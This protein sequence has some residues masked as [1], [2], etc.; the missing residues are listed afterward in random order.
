M[1]EELGL[2][3]V[4]EPDTT[5]LDE[6]L[7]GIK[8]GTPIKMPVTV[9]TSGISSKNIE[10]KLGKV[11]VEVDIDDS[12]INAYKSRLKGLGFGD[13]AVKDAVKALNSMGIQVKKVRSNID[14]V[15]AAG[16]KLKSVIFDGVNAEGDAVRVTQQYNL[17]KKKQLET[18]IS[19]T[20]EYEKQVKA[21]KNVAEETAKWKTTQENA[22]KDLVSKAKNQTKPLEQACSG[23]FDGIVSNIRNA[24]NQVGDS[25]TAETKNSVS[26]MMADAARALKEA[27]N[28]QYVATSLRTKDIETVKTIQGNTLSAFE[29]KIKGAGMS[30]EMSTTV[31][32]L[33]ENLAK[34]FDANSLT[35]W[36]NQLD[37]ARSKLDALTAEVKAQAAVEKAAAKAQTD[38]EKATKKAQKEQSQ[39]NIFNS[40]K[41]TA[42]TKLDSRIQELERA[43]QYAGKIKDD[44]D[45]LKLSLE[46]VTNA[47][48]L[49]A[50][51]AELEIA[52]AKVKQFQDS[53]SALANQQADDIGSNQL[54]QIEEFQQRL[55][56]FG[57][58]E[59]FNNLR[60][61]LENLKSQ[62]QDVVNLLNNPDLSEAEYSALTKRIKELDQQ[63]KKTAS[64]M[65]KFG[66]DDKSQQYIA[67]MESNIAKLKENFAA[68]KENWSA[69]MDVPE[70]KTQIDAFEQRLQGVDASNVGEVQAAFQRL[71]SAIKSAG[72]DC[73]SFSS[74]LSEIKQYATQLFSWQQIAQ[75]AKKFFTEVVKNVKSLDSA[76][77]ELKKVTDLTSAGYDKFLSNAGSRAK[78]I[79]TSMSSYIEGVGDFAKLGYSVEDATA[80]SEAANIL[81]KVGD[82]FNSIEDSSDTIIASMKAYGIAASDVTSVIDKLNEVSNKTSITTSGLSEAIT[83]SASALSA[84]GLSFDKSLALIVAGNESTRDPSMVGN[85]LKTLSLRIRGAETELEALGEETDEYVKSTSK[86]REEVKALTG[87]DIMIDDSQFKDLYD[88]MDE[89]EEKFLALSDIDRANLMDILFG[90]QRA[91]VG[92][93]ILQNFDQ[94]E[95]ALETA[96]NA[97]GSAMTEHSRWMESI[98]ASE[99]KATAAFEELSSKIMSSDI[100]KFFYDAKTGISEF[101][102]S[103]IDSTGSAIPLVASLGATLASLKSNLGISIVNMPCFAGYGVAA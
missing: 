51:T 35:A 58:T 36:L 56:N 20:H 91:N 54:K 40:K 67:R 28:K 41:E 102:S 61:Q 33:K 27:Q 55:N 88:I 21:Q 83:R 23:T 9:D 43:G 6:A 50:W 38:A 95:R 94:A 77:T 18:N 60:N 78:V 80:L 31:A 3:I 49:R 7:K 65:S 100:V 70:L 14:E 5:K 79:G 86:M 42:S 47:D 32:A 19:I 62:Y 76:M 45:S 11:N 68:M 29:S 16:Q 99:A 85:A 64:T 30:G 74:K 103:I 73:Q 59:G 63:L 96:Q 84:S 48:E 17:S 81:Y 22:L 4:L 75:S 39:Q 98:E 26:T 57:N 92:A 69:A 89:L 97:A 2:K 87:V 44:F 1:A 52:E 8:N 101:F 25:V 15:N 13:L 10:K 71:R 53:T 82:G 93:S 66:N 12:A 90:K 24:L 72:A 37:I 34:V 46:N